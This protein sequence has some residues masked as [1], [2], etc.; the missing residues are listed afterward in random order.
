MLEV[1]VLNFWFCLK[2]RPDNCGLKPG[3]I[4][5]TFYLKELTKSHV[6]ASVSYKST[7]LKTSDI[8]DIFIKV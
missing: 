7:K 6:F 1:L 3:E 8:I 5:I 4:I 2:S